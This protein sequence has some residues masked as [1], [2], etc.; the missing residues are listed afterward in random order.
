MSELPRAR[1]RC[2]NPVRHD[3]PTC[4][5]VLCLANDIYETTLI[6]EKGLHA[7]R[8]EQGAKP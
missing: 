3:R 7:N 4:G 6:A 1:C 5:I 8:K 2:G